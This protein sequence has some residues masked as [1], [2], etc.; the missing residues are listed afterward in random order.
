MLCRLECRKGDRRR[1]SSLSED[2]VGR[3]GVIVQVLLKKKC[4]YILIN[5][6]SKW[7]RVK[8]NQ[9]KR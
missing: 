4:F 3:Y 1:R 2:V 8:L 7:E 5:L 6:F 9:F